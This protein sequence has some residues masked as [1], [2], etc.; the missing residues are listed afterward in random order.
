MNAAGR[1]YASV[2]LSSKRLSGVNLSNARLANSKFDKS[3]AYMVRFDESDLSDSSFL[4]TFLGDAS[5]RGANLSRTT[6]A[7]ADLTGADFSGAVMTGAILE[8]AAT[9]GCK[10]VGADLS[11]AKMA[12]MGFT[13][14]VYRGTVHIDAVQL[15]Y[16][17]SI[18]TYS[19]EDSHTLNLSGARLDGADLRGALLAGS[20]VTEEQLKSAC[21][22]YMTELP[23]E[24]PDLKRCTHCP[25]PTDPTKEDQHCF[26]SQQSRVDWLSKQPRSPVQPGEERLLEG[27]R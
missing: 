3:N 12:L 10:F 15:R 11:N 9:R 6:F 14:G 18:D 4:D 5:L 27:R 26:T 1:S 23:P 19:I 13:N 21:I 25:A 22:D 2:D 17:A 16:N 24:L 20:M 7:A 8:G